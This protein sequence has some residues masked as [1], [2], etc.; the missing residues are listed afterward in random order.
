MFPS[1]GDI[2]TADVRPEL[3]ANSLPNSIAVLTLAGFRSFMAECFARLRL[4]AF[5]VQISR[6]GTQAEATKEGFKTRGRYPNLLNAT[7]MEKF[8]ALTHEEYAKRFGHDCVLV[9][10]WGVDP[11]AA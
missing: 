3:Q 10:A 5:A 8:V 4:S 11:L 9:A 6:E 1:R 2:S 7:A